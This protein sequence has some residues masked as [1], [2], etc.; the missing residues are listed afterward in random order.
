MLA[1]FNGVVTG[2]QTDNRTGSCTDQCALGSFAGLGLLRIRIQ[3]LTAGESDRRDNYNKRKFSG[4]HLISSLFAQTKRWQ[5]I[6]NNR[7]VVP[8]K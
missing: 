7:S 3:C 2:Y 8:D 4:T 1:P 6:N 5:Q